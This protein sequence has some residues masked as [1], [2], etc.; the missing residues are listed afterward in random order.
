ME[1]G[2]SVVKH[3]LAVF[4]IAF[5]AVGFIKSGSYKVVESLFDYLKQTDYKAEGAITVSGIEADFNEGGVETKGID[6][7]KWIPLKAN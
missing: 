3:L 4:F 5:L 1:K 6:K 7:S 2:N